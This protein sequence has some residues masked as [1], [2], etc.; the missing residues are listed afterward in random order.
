MNKNKPKLLNWAEFNQFMF[1]GEH[2]VPLEIHFEYIHNL[3]FLVSN[4]T[5]DVLNLWES[6]SGLYSIVEIT[7]IQ[8]VVYMIPYKPQSIC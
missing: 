4:S 5:E 1:F 2:W 3:T 7:S 8:F 6:E